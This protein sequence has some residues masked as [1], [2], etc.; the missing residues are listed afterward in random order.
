VSSLSAIVTP[1]KTAFI[2]SSLSCQTYPGPPAVERVPATRLVG[3][4]PR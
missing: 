2:A 4:Q 3:V 1:L